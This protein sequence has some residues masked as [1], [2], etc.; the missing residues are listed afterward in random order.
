MSEFVCGLNKTEDE[1]A[2]TGL[3]LI[4][5]GAGCCADHVTWFC[6]HMIKT[7]IWISHTHKATTLQESCVLHSGHIY[8]LL[9]SCFCSLIKCQIHQQSLQCIS[10]SYQVPAY[11]I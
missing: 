1:A 4:T 2:S 7:T 10:I 3:N 8:D 11:Q 9:V 6:S 5:G